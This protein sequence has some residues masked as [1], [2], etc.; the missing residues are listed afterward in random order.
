MIVEKYTYTH[1]FMVC[2]INS[3][4]KQLKYPYLKYQVYHT[5]AVL[6]FKNLLEEEVSTSFHRIFCGSIIIKSCPRAI[7][8]KISHSNWNIFSIIYS[9]NSKITDSQGTI[10]L[11]IFHFCIYFIG[12]KNLKFIFNLF[13]FTQKGM[14]IVN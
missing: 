8:I 4:P 7:K 1:N 11:E 9:K 14:S 10:S 3:Q 12:Q 2:K 6:N 13:I 5:K